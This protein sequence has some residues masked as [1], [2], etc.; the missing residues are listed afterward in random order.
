[1][2]EKNAGWPKGLPKSTLSTLWAFIT[3]SFATY[4]R[5]STGFFF[6]GNTD[7]DTVVYHNLSS[8]IRARY[9]RFRPTSW[10]G[11][12]TMRVELYGCLGDVKFWIADKDS[13]VV[14]QMICNSLIFYPLCERYRALL[15]NFVFLNIWASQKGYSIFHFT[16]MVLLA[17][18]YNLFFNSQ[19]SDQKCCEEHMFQHRH[20][21]SSVSRFHWT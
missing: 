6:A 14:E 8:P 21:D 7:Q 1:M 10:I 13:W 19:D 16:L 4:P 2:L 15:F 12:V 3:E 5:I 18:N 20:L 11:G 17:L 9:I